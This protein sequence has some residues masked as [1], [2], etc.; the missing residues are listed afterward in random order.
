MY[1]HLTDA[2]L[3]N[4]LA[5]CSLLYFYYNYAFSVCFLA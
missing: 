4:S 5:Q 1:G 2:L 3:V